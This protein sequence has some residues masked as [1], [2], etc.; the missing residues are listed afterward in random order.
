MR[1]TRIAAALGAITLLGAAAPP[2]KRIVSLNLC[3]DE[4]VVALAD[5]EQIAGL[6]EWVRD[7]E[8]SA[9]AARARMLPVTHRSVEEVLA[10]HP[11]V[12]I[13]APLRT[14][15]SLARL[16]PGGI[17]M[18]DLPMTDGEAGI[19]DSITTIAAAVGHPDRGTAMIARIRHDLAAIGPPP[20]RGRIAAHYQRQGYLT[21]SGTLV[22]DMIRRVGL[23]NLATR[24]NRPPLSKLSLEEMALARPAFLLMDSGTRTVADRGT[25][26]LHHPILDRAI[27]PGRRLHIPQALTVCGGPAYP[28]AVALLARQIRAADAGRR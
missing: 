6:T 13:G 28:R 17:R 25:A 8:M 27:P 16:N 5:R 26:A 23:V 10:L 4:L 21:G 9:V 12:V 3:A 11:D 14:A 19:A 18:V 7:P 20:G 24:L 15:A 22:D 2:P 1:V